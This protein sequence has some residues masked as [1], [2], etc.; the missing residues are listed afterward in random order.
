[1]TTEMSLIPGIS[2]VYFDGEHAKA[3]AVRLVASG[4][5]I[6]VLE[7]GGTRLLGQIDLARDTLFER[8]ANAPLQITLTN[9]ASIEVPQTPAAQ[10]MLSAAG[11]TDSPVA[12]WQRR[13]PLVLA[14]LL[15][16]LAGSLMAYVHL[17]PRAVAW[18]ALQLPDVYLHKLDAQLLDKL[19]RNRLQPS[20]LPAVRQAEIAERFGAA[21]AR[22][23]PD[24]EYRLLFRSIPGPQGINAFALP[25]GTIVLLDGLV[26]FLGAPEV[27]DD[28]ILA[29]LGHEL[30]HVAKRHVLRR[31]IQTTAVALAAT[32]LWGD[33]AGLATNT[34]ALVSALSY[35]R[36]MEVEADD[37]AVAFLLAN[38]KTAAPL[39]GVFIE[40]ERLDGKASKSE[41]LSTHPSSRERRERIRS[42]P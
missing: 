3:T 39:V 41:F 5:F 42:A 38:G 6:Q 11:A 37:F 24:V 2:A 27:S 4:R 18:T 17:L 40:F 35:S 25:G 7:E 19:D 33:A 23:A 20:K 26:E 12:R 32:F 28:R 34:P 14:L 22:F 1:M 10:A 13:W 16:L 9:G 8:F 29:V 31:L 30:G 21:A 36:E 15:L